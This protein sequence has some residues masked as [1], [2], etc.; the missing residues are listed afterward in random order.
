[1][2]YQETATINMIL[3]LNFVHLILGQ[4]NHAIFIRQKSIVILYCTP[5]T[6]YTYLLV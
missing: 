3:S 6:H 4:M 2:F 5:A 1:M